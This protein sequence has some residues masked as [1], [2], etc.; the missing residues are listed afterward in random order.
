MAC[1]FPTLSEL[2]DNYFRTD[3]IEDWGRY[4]LQND[5]C[6]ETIVQK[7]RFRFAVEDRFDDLI[8]IKC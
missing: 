6:T 7:D 5:L 3:Y 1:Q 4:F 2:R 8:V